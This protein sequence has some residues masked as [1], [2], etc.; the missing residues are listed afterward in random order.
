MRIKAL[1]LVGAF[2]VGSAVCWAALNVTS[3]PGTVVTLQEEA[4]GPEFADPTQLDI[5]TA[6]TRKRICPSTTQRWVWRW[7]DYRGERVQRVYPLVATAAPFLGDSGKVL[8]TVPNPGVPDLDKPWFYRTVTVETCGFLPTWLGSLF[9]SRI[10]RSPDMQVNFV[11][12][13]HR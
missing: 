12:A 11:G 3:G 13:P 4:E 6:F 5:L 7:E 1:A 2:C 8:F 9:G 10:Y